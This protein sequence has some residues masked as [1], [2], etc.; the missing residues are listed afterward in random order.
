MNDTLGVA[1]GQL[2]CSKVLVL[3]MKSCRAVDLYVSRVSGY[4]TTVT[5]EE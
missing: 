2:G 1:M 3:A 4:L 5:P